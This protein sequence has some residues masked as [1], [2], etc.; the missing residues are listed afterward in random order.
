M[1]A[2]EPIE[3]QFERLATELGVSHQE[4]SLQLVQGGTSFTVR[5]IASRPSPSFSIEASWREPRGAR[6]QTLVSVMQGPPVTRLAE[7]AKR[8]VKAPTGDAEFDAAM[9]VT[10]RA[11]P[12][13]VPALLGRQARRAVVALI[14]D[15]WHTVEVTTRSVVVRRMR[16]GGVVGASVI[17]AALEPLATIAAAARANAGIL[18]VTLPR[19][20]F[21]LLGVPAYL[22]F[23]AATLAFMRSIAIA[24]APGAWPFLTSFALGVLATAVIAVVAVLSLRGRSTSSIDAAVWTLAAAAL[25]P[26]GLTSILPALD[27]ALDRSEATEWQATLVAIER[28]AKGPGRLRLRR[29]TDGK[30]FAVMNYGWSCRGGEGSPVVLRVRGGFFGWAWID[31][32]RDDP[33]PAR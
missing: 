6:E 32:I 7:R 25:L 8:T 24:F 14:D 2:S 10:S 3:R 9:V 33:A 23:L 19:T 15:D 28:T 11:P 5:A 27:V 22:F 20:P 31:A 30:E 17:R 21:E 16:M 12:A 18:P 29:A 4:L 1:P 26:A 13:V